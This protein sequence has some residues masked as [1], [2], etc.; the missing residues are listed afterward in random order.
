MKGVSTVITTSALILITVALLALILPWAWNLI[1]QTTNTLTG[2]T[3]TKQRAIL[4]DVYFVLPSALN[5]SKTNQLVFVLNSG[6]IALTNARIKMLDTNLDVFDI[7]FF[8][9]RRDGTNVGDRTNPVQV[10]D[11]FYPGDVIVGILPAEDNYLGYQFVFQSR[12]YSEAVK[13]GG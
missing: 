5:P 13:V 7:N 4:G 8:V 11:V 6:Y 2:N 1:V 3:Q 9:L 10:V 12:E